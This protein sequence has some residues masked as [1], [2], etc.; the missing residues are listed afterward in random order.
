MR[1]GSYE[2]PDELLYNKDHSWVRL[3]G[4]T[5]TLGVTS[6]AAGMAQEFVFVQLPKKGDQ[7][8]KGDTYISLEAVKW[9]GHLASPLSGQVVDVN[10]AIFN[11][12]GE[13][14]K[15]PYESWLIKLKLTNPDEKNEL[16]KPEQ[17]KDWVGEITKGK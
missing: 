8:K 4:D 5:A 7:I 12:P 2:L 9:S 14:N 3:E 6:V 16:L 17:L 11:N 1:I 13:I 15:R 10:E